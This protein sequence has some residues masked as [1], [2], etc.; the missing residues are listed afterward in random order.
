MKN[1]YPNI[2]AAMAAIIYR[3]KSGYAGEAINTK[4]VR[5]FQNRLCDKEKIR[6][7]FIKIFRRKKV[8]FAH[9]LA[10]YYGSSA[11]G[12]KA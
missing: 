4:H 9:F 1:R 2:K 7:H 12:C 3:N 10:N 11:G 6:G 5:I 8:F